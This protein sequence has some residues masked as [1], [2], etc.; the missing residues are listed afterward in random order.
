MIEKLRE[1]L[2]STGGTIAGVVV[3]LVAVAAA[4]MSLKSSLGQSEA[5]AM[6]NNKPFVDAE[7]LK[8]FTYVPKLG[9]T[10]PVASPF[11]GKR[12]GYPA[13]L[14]FWTKDGKEKAEPT[15]VLMNQAVGKS[16][17]TFCPDCGRLVTL[18]NQRPGP[19]AKV[20]PTKDEAAARKPATHD[21]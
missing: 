16:G 12:T 4:A 2:K 21:E 14:C 3:T 13:E 18:Y 17:P 9:D 6:A 7:T 10:I 11:T 5:A 19:T 8:G 15:Y 20:P 1:F